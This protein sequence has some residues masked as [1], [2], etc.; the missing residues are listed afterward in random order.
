ML[1][2]SMGSFLLQHY[3][4]DA[5]NSLAGAI[6]S[7]T[8]GGFGPSAKIGLLLLRAEA[9]IYGRRHPSAVGERLSF[10]AFNK[11]FEPARTKFDWLSRDA[12][13][14]DAYV[15]DPDCG[16]RCSTGLWLD[17]FEAGLQLTAPQRLRRIPKALPILMIAGSEDPVSAGES[18]PRMLEQKY[19]ASGIR[20]ITMR[21]YPGARHELFNETCRDEVTRDLVAWLDAHG[22]PS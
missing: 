20:D 9:L 18:G 19:A 5:G 15:A 1:G 6:F 17:L 14:V 22:K 11:K 4:A 8:A 21:V 12:R 7:A 10:A 3:V 13:E 16:Y 2:H